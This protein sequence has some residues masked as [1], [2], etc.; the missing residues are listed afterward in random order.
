MNSMLLLNDESEDIKKEML[1]QQHLENLQ[2][3]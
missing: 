1:R 3:R 2:R